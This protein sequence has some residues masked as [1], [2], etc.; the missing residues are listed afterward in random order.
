M[1]KSGIAQQWCPCGSNIQPHIAVAI[2]ARS[3]H[4][5][6]RQ[7]S[8]PITLYIC[9]KCV[10]KFDSAISDQQQFFRFVHSRVRDRILGAVAGTLLTVWEE[11]AARVPK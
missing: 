9:E 10:R 7:N 11:I 6:P 8:A 2:T 5:V 4:V 3:L 1:P